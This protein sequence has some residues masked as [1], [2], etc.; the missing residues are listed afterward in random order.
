MDINNTENQK[1]LKEDKNDLPFCE[2]AETAEHSRLWED[3]APCD[4]SINGRV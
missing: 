3:D 4:S 2:K 1:E